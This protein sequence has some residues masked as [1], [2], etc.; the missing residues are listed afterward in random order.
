MDLLAK[1]I[2]TDTASPIYQ[3]I[4]EKEYSLVNSNSANFEN[5]AKSAL[6]LGLFPKLAKK[7][8]KGKSI[9]R[10]SIKTHPTQEEMLERR[11]QKAQEATRKKRNEIRAKKRSMYGPKSGGYRK[12]RKNKRN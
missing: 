8:K 3:E 7:A 2:G 1:R 9:M 5:I 11:R 10:K 12:T 6:Q 4:Q